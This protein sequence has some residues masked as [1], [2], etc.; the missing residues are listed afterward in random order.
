MFNDYKN[1]L[2]KNEIILESQ[3]RFRSEAHCV[4]S[5]KYKVCEN[6]M[7]SKYK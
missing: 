2:F 1:C 5:I 7:L 4:Y 6:E 3:K